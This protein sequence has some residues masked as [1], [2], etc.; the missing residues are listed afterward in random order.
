MRKLTINVTDRT[1]LALQ[2]AAARRGCTI[3]GLIE[4]ILE[5]KGIASSAEVLEIVAR[6]RSSS[7]LGIKEA[8]AIAVRETSLHRAERG[9]QRGAL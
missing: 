1:H 7:G 5:L 8:M 3:N 2:E 9:E 6:A 4:E